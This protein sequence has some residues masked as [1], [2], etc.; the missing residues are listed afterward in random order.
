VSNGAVRE[1]MLEAVE[2]CLGR[3]RRASDYRGRGCEFYAEIESW[4]EVAFDEMAV[5]VE[6]E[7]GR[8]VFP[9]RSE[10]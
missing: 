1:G 4:A 8:M 9:H 7:A 6:G 2:M 5:G 10:L 3:S